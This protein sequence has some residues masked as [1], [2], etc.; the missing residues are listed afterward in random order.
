MSADYCEWSDLPASQCA[1]CRGLDAPG[2]DLDAPDR[3]ERRTG[4]TVAPRFRTGNAKIAAHYTH[5]C[6]GCGDPI[7][8]GDPIKR[9]SADIWVH[10]EC[11]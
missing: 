2:V 9:D 10:Q 11:A 8:P 1:H 5:S 3:E 6:A 4:D 7:E